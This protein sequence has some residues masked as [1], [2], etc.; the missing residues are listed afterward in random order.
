VGNDI[1]ITRPDHLAEKIVIV[2]G[3]AGC[4]KT[5][6]SPIVSA[7]DRVELLTYA[8]ELEYACALASLGKMDQDAARGL[9]RLLTDLQIYNTMMGRELN[10]RPADLSSIWRDANPLRYVKRMFQA[11]DESV[12]DR[13]KSERPILHLT[14]HNLLPFAQPVFEALNDR[15]VFVE[16]VRHPLYMLKQQAL[17]MKNIHGD[18]R[19]FTVYYEHQGKQVPFFAREWQERFLTGTDVEKVIYG[20]DALYKKAE[21]IRK[22][23]S[24]RIITIPFEK[25]VLDPMPYMGQLCGTLGTQ[26]TSVTT[27]M[28]RKQKVPRKKIADGIA[29]KIYKRCGWTPPQAGGDERAE[30]NLRREF[31]KASAS[32]EAMNVLDNLCADYEKTYLTKETV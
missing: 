11:G 12:P 28:M 10:C 24:K 15:L 7:L 13:I 26:M 23:F 9:T 31:A 5:M 4:G 19:D 27:N 6:L 20:M 25:F 2:D 29:L 16:V 32:S 14:T 21:K 22:Q 30:L 8:Y 1:V 3:Q 18:V 17:N